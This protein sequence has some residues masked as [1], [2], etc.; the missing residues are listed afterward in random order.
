MTHPLHLLSGPGAAGDDGGAPQSV[1]GRVWVARVIPSQLSQSEASIVPSD[2][3]EASH[4]SS[5]RH[6]GTQKQSAI[7]HRQI[8]PIFIFTKVS[9]ISEIVNKVNTDSKPAIIWLS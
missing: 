3:S 7:D 6:V 5:H 8:W 1:P 4:H 2:Q 9:K